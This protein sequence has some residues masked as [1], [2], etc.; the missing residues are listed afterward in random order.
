MIEKLG[1]GYDEIKKIL[2]RASKGRAITTGA[3]NYPS[4]E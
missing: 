4:P 2:V 1:P 3:G